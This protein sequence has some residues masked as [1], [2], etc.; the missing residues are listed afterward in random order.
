MGYFKHTRMAIA[1]GNYIGDPKLDFSIVESRWI[2]PQF[3]R[4]LFTLEP[5]FKHMRPKQLSCVSEN[6]NASMKNIFLSLY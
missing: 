2:N 1:F 3:V 5:H 6:C 4:D